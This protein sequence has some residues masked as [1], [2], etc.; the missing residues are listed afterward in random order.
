M[1]TVT[2]STSLILVTT[3]NGTG[4]YTVKF[5]NISTTGRIITVRDNDGFASTNNAIVLQAISG[6]TFQGISGTLSINQPFGFITL[7][8]Q[9]NGVYGVLNTFAFP[10]GSATASVS[11][12]TT[13]NLATQSTIQIRDRTTGAYKTL[14]TSSGQLI[15]NNAPV[16]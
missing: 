10:A 9:A 6:A 4:P 2:A 8:S 5:P 7:N 13:T 16:G 1:T 12:I 11:N 15:V 3:S 14:Y